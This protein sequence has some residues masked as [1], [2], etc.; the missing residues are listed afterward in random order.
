L[1]HLLFSLPPYIAARN[2]LSST[3]RFAP[4]QAS[5]RVRCDAKRTRIERVSAPVLGLVLVFL[6]RQPPAP[7]T[8][9]DLFVAS[10]FGAFVLVAFSLLR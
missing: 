10:A 7:F 4:E 5:A 3:E 8:R 1:W 2:G 9:V 6:A